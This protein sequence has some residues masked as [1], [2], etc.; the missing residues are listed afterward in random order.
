MTHHTHKE[1][2][3]SNPY[4]LRFSMLMEAKNLL[5]EEYHARKEEL[6]DRYHALKDAGETVAYP[7]LP[8]YPNFED[9]QDLCKEMNAFVSDTGGKH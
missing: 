8:K 7:I 1:I 2:N 6:V 5:A 3:M 9:I 4:E